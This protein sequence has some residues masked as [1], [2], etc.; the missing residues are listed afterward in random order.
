MT[1]A[2]HRLSDTEWLV[3][4]DLSQTE[5]DY[6]TM[7]REICNSVGLKPEQVL[8]LWGSPCETIIIS[9]RQEQ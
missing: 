1:L 6:H 3:L 5:Y 2:Q 8:L 7:L 4:T 9:S